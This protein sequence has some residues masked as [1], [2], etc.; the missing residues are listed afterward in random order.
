MTTGL[1]VPAKDAYVLFTDR[2]AVTCSLEGLTDETLDVYN[3]WL[4]RAPDFILRLE[5]ARKAFTGERFAT[6]LATRHAYGGID[7]ARRLSYPL[8]VSIADLFTTVFEE[9]RYPGDP[10]DA[11]RDSTF[12]FAH[13]DYGAF[14]SEEYRMRPCSSVRFGSGSVF[15][16]DSSQDAEALE[17]G[18]L[19][20]DDAVRVGYRWF[21]DA[22][23]RDPFSSGVECTIITDDGCE[24]HVLDEPRLDANLAPYLRFYRN[25]VNAEAFDRFEK[26]YASMFV[27]RSRLGP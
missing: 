21:S 7:V 23:S 24:Q 11:A 17:S 3:D 1:L 12:V 26:R 13:R 19:G 14:R 16:D 6:A 8:E 20:L 22:V 5:Y 9:K 4:V 15:F 27:M 18:A 25:A 10:I 2:L